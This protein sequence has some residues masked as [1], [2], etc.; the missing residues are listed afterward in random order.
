MAPKAD[1]RADAAVKMVVLSKG[2]VMPQEAW[3][4]HGEPGT[5][6]NIRRRV[7]RELAA[8]EREVEANEARRAV[9]ELWASCASGPVPSTSD[10]LSAQAPRRRAAPAAA[11]SRAPAN[12]SSARSHGKNTVT[13]WRANTR[14]GR[15]ETPPETGKGAR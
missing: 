14:P 8:Q 7:R 12:A 15:A 11:V 4:A 1:P 2:T 3:R 5:L 9:K 13:P 10:P 6:D